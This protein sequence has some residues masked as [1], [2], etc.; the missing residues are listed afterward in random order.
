MADVADKIIRFTNVT[1]TPQKLV[2]TLKQRSPKLNNIAGG[3]SDRYLPGIN[4]SS[5]YSSGVGSRFGEVDPPETDSLLKSLQ[6]FWGL[7]FNHFRNVMAEVVGISGDDDEMDKQLLSLVEA[8]LKDYNSVFLRAR[9]SAKLL[10]LEYYK[11]GKRY[12]GCAAADK[13]LEAL[14]K[15]GD[16]Q[17]WTSRDNAEVG[18]LRAL[19]VEY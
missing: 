12:E 5:S 18:T 14:E 2:E 19:T 6:N 15:E 3:C 11:Q 10:P 17:V 13:F 7:R 9:L 1:G 8:L 4:L 16:R